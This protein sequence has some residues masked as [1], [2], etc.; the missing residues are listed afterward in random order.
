MDKENKRRTCKRILSGETN[1]CTN[2][3]AIE[4][5]LEPPRRRSARLIAISK[6]TTVETKATMNR[7]VNDEQF[8]SL[9]IFTDSNTEPNVVFDEIHQN[10]TNESKPIRKKRYSTTETKP[11]GNTSKKKNDIIQLPQTNLVDDVKLKDTLNDSRFTSTFDDILSPNALLSLTPTTSSNLFVQQKLPT[12]II[13]KE[14]ILT[15]ESTDNAEDDWEAMESIDNLTT[16]TKEKKKIVEVKLEGKAAEKFKIEMNSFEMQNAKEAEE[17]AK[18]EHC[19]HLEIKRRQKQLQEDMHRIHV[20]CYIGHLHFM[21]TKLTENRELISAKFKLLFDQTTVLSPITPNQMQEVLEDV[22]RAN[23]N[24]NNNTLAYKPPLKWCTNGSP[25]INHVI[26]MIDHKCFHT[27]RECSLVSFF[28]ILNSHHFSC[29][30]PFA[31]LYWNC[32]LDFVLRS[33][34]CQN[35]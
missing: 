7:D 31:I 34:Q 30:L 13:E 27:D 11:K 6:P 24:Q 1:Q 22:F 2:E 4:S 5:E 17:R 32:L 21:L 8:G 26:E 3:K 29:S 33:I 20:L 10:S 28:L 14:E 25:F 15:S 19:M 23:F 12:K 9:K 35:C 18:W 16:I